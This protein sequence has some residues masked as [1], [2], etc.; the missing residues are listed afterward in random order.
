M[1]FAMLYDSLPY[2]LWGAWPD[3]PLGGAALTVLLSLGSGLVSAVLGL[4]LGIALVLLTGGARRVLTAVL[5]FLRA[6]PVLMH[7]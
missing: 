2:L 5:S 3:G 1:N 4:G 6:I 7:K